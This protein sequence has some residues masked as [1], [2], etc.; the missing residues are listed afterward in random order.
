MSDR[1]THITKKKMEIEKLTKQQIRLIT[2]AT[3]LVAKPYKRQS[4]GL[5]RINQSLAIFFQARMIEAQKQMIIAQPI[6]NY[7]PG[8][9]VPVG[10]AIVG[11]I[12]PEL[13]LTPN[14]AFTTTNKYPHPHQLPPGP[15]RPVFGIDQDSNV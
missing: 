11:E 7:V 14:G 10:I 6:P 3:A 4:T 9:I 5:R 15:I 13:I 12:G 8:D 1:E 2:K